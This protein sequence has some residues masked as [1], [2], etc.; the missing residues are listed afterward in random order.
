MD[1]LDIGVAGT[2][3]NNKPL[4]G[5]T[6]IHNGWLFHPRPHPPRQGLM[7]GTSSARVLMP[8]FW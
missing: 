7:A 6:M 8:S 5:I 3:W 1:T 4:W 2:G